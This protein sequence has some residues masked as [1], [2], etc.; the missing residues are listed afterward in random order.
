MRMMK[1]PRIVQTTPVRLA[2]AYV[3]ACAAALGFALAALL[4]SM[5]WFSDSAVEQELAQEYRMLNADPGAL[6]EAVQSRLAGAVEQ[7]RF[8]LVV[9]ADDHKLV[10]NLRLWPPEPEIPLDG[11]V[12]S[13]WVDEDAFPAGLYEDEPYLPIVATRLPDGRRL[14]LA[15]G[16]GQTG[17]L[18][19]LTLYLA[20]VLSV[21]AVLSLILGIVIGRAILRRMD[22]VSRTAGE[23][24]RGD[25]AQR[26]PLSGRSGDEFD[27]LAGR[28]NAMLDR[29]QQLVRGLREV[30][31]N[32]AHDLRR[33]LTQL[34][35]RMDVTLLAPRGEEEYRRV[36]AQGVQDADSLIQTFN[37]LLDIA[38]A[39][40]EAGHQ[41]SDWGPVNLNDLAHD[42]AELYE[43]VAEDQGLQFDLDVTPGVSITGSRALLAQAI[44]NLLE[45]AIKYTPAGGRVRLQVRWS[46]SGIAEVQVSDTGRGVPESEREHVL[47][48]F[49]RLDD[50]RNTPGNGLGLS[51]V[52]AVA[53]SHRA[54]LLLDDAAPGLRVRLRFSGVS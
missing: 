29:I 5:R 48:R 9:A 54:Q 15:R 45:N 52:K 4:W 21:A 18:R 43:P 28:L 49:V 35:N 11:R 7:R 20:E 19:D 50:S 37:A 25:L 26:V 33:P 6:V 34:R 41:R 17:P 39:E 8:Y 31:D 2:L 1:L 44:G 42:L 32:V 38:Q 27:V 47:E 46:Q 16:V 22:V 12:R 30:S 3:L 10:G 14:L 23:I 40:A 36:L 53:T 13:L 51:L 24:L